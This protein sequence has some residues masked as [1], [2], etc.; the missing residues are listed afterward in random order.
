MILDDVIP[1]VAKHSSTLEKFKIK[2]RGVLKR[3]KV[4]LLMFLVDVITMFGISKI[5]LMFKGTWHI[6]MRDEVIPI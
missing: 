3:I 4:I 6:K 1:L 2:Y 5:L